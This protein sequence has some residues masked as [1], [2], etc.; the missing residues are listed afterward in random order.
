M[1]KLS[2]KFLS[3]KGREFLID[4]EII[5]AGE[6]LIVI[7]TGGKKHIGAISLSYSDKTKDRLTATLPVS[8]HKEDFITPDIAAEITNATGKT[9]A[10]IAGMHW[11]SLEKQ[12][13]SLIIDKLSEL[14]LKIIEYLTS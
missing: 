11:D 7:I 5:K 8:G 3:P 1:K 2:L 12:E 4:A 13:L 10:V 14:K 9:T 6:D